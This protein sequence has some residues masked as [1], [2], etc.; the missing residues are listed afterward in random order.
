MT[1]QHILIA[2]SERSRHEF[3]RYDLA[4]GLWHPAPR[5]RVIQAQVT[6]LVSEIEK[7]G[8]I[9][10]L[11]IAPDRK[12]ETFARPDAISMP[13]AA[14]IVALLPIDPKPD[15]FAL[16]RMR[17]WQ[18]LT[19]ISPNEAPILGEKIRQN[20]IA[21]WLRQ[22]FE[23]PGTPQ[24]W[25]SGR[26]PSAEIWIRPNW[27]PAQIFGDKLDMNGQPDE[28]T[29]ALTDELQHQAAPEVARQPAPKRPA[30]KRLTKPKVKTHDKAR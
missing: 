25:A 21:G 30:P 7:R 14:N 11:T 1:L 3:D 4:G 6:D 18:R 24:L 19:F 27:T 8:A 9:F 5:A 26:Q 2:R 12:A 13:R 17:L 10:D 16:E 23:A 29:P 15:D 22:I 20:A 28:A